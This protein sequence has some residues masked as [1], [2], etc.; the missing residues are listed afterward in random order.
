MKFPNI[1]YVLAALTIVGTALFFVYYAYVLQ[2]RRGTTEWIDRA[3]QKPR[4]RYAFKSHPMEKRDIAPLAILLAVF[5]FVSF[6]ELGDF[7]A[8][9]TFYKFTESNKSTVV[10]LPQSTH[11]TGVMFYTGL[12]P[13]TEP[14]AGYTLE[15]SPDG[16]AW[17]PV[18]PPE[19]KETVMAQTHA[20]LFKWRN[21]DIG[22][23][24]EARLLRI[25]ALKPLTEL[26]ELAILDGGGIVAASGDAYELFDEQELIPARPSYMNGMYFDEI[27]HG[28]AGYETLRSIYPYE[29]VHPPLGKTIISLGID[30]FG[31]TPFG[32]R[33]MGT[34]FGVGM[35]AVLYV[36]LKNMFGRTLIAVCGTLLLAF[37]FMR[38]TQSRLATVDTYPV[39]FILL[40]YLFMYRYIAQD[41]HTPFRESLR[42]LA[43]AG[44]FFGIGAACKWIVIYA[45]AGL[46]VMYVIKLI[47]DYKYYYEDGEPG[48][49]LPRVIKTLAATAL[50]FIAI[51]VIIYCLSY[52]PYGRARGMTVKNGMLWNP[53]YYKMIWKVQ[54]NTFNYHS[55]GVLDAV[56]PYSS[57][58]YQ[59]VADERPILYYLDYPAAGMKST[60]GAFGNPIIWWGGFAA[61][62]TMVYRTVRYKDAKALLIVI[63]FLSQILPWLLVRRIVFVYHYFPSTLFLVLALAHMFDTLAERG[64]RLGRRVAVAFTSASGA[65]FVLFYPVLSGMTM[66]N[67]YFEKVLKWFPSW[68]F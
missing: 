61:V 34:L 4:F 35:L 15:Y 42:P 36:L 23:G 31:M 25:T 12:I 53:E 26:G 33:C 62:V 38:F 60:F 1:T 10:T 13:R 45:G 59:W 28:R 6:W 55:K 27:Y 8:P 63:G 65:L 44:L 29:T 46:F 20:D 21:A 37:D 9:Q 41:G 40:S 56:H 43:F 57:W 2:P 47:T 14:N 11:V 49:Y 52:M 51:P 64:E 32:W 17:M 19:G 50:F 5:A 68:P 22:S 39:F 18:E 58:W 66:P 24:F 67:A 3:V 16:Y 7:V 48:L 30:L 54:V